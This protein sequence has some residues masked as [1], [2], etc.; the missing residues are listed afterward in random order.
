MRYDEVRRNIRTLRLG[1]SR[2]VPSGRSFALW[3]LRQ[4]QLWRR[5]HRSSQH[6]SRLWVFPMGRDA[7]SRRDPATKL[8][9]IAIAISDANGQQ[10]HSM[11]LLARE[12]RGHDG[13]VRKVATCGWDRRVGAAKVTG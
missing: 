8:G 13:S 7:G 1:A 2:I 5:S 10:A 3:L 6:F 4:T 11:P 9:M 12:F